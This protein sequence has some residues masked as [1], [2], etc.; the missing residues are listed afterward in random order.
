MPLGI[1]VHDISE[2]LIYVRLSC[3]VHKRVFTVICGRRNWV[4]RTAR[5]T[6]NYYNDTQ[7]LVPKVVDPLLGTLA[8]GGEITRK[9][10]AF[11]R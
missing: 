5:F 3:S 11:A 2:S 1:E 8:A 4:L 6:Q 10:H 7:P 9:I